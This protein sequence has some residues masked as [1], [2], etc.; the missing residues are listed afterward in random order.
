MLWGAL[1]GMLNCVQC[2]ERREGQFT[3]L[4]QCALPDQKAHHNCADHDVQRINR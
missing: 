3:F 1:G 4:S 2:P